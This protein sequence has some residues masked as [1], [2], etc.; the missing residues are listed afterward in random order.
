MRQLSISQMILHLMHFLMIA[1]FEIA[2]SII[3]VS[4]QGEPVENYSGGSV[5][6]MAMNNI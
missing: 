6:E 2:I 5:T 1:S 4:P 3:T